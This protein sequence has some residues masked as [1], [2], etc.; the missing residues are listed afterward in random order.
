MFANP[1]TGKSTLSWSA[2]AA[3]DL[4]GYEV[5]GLD[6]GDYVQIGTSFV[7]RYELPELTDA[8]TFAVRAYDTS[9]NRSPYSLYDVGGVSE[10][11]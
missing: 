4:A 1:I 2:S 9:G 11:L 5:F 3:P 6:G 8:S 10:D 7:A